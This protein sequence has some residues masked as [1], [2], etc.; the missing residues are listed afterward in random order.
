MPAPGPPARKACVSRPLLFPGRRGVRAGARRGVGAPDRHHEVKRSRPIAA[1]RVKPGSA[2]VLAAALLAAACAVAWLVRPELLLIVSAYVVNNVAYTVLLKRKLVADVLSISLGFM[3]RILA[4]AVAVGV[5]PSS[6][7]MICGFSISLFLGFCKRRSE[8]GRYADPQ[9]AGAARHVLYHY[10]AEKLNLLAGS[11]A[12]LTLVTYMLFTVSPQTVA[13]HGTSDLI[14]TTPFVV[15]GIFRF[16]LKSIDLRG[17]DAAET[18]LKDHG[19]LLAGLGW[20]LA[21]VWILY[22]SPGAT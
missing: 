1:G 14:Y 5:E 19:F 4:G 12:T 7:L 2:T 3:L 18:I 22:L 13:R 15:Y 16:L 17:E 9:E 10:T 6:W 11:T 8:C 20:V 21:V